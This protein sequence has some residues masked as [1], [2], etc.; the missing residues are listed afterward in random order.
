VDLRDKA[1]EYLMLPS[2]AAYLI[3]AQDRCKAWLWV[4]G[5]HGFPAGPAIIVG[6][7]Q[8]I[9]IAPLD[10]VLPLGVLYAGLQ[11]T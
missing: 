9:R 2:L 11:V 1:A 3:L 8:S 6:L 4:R 10:L 5:E 7:D